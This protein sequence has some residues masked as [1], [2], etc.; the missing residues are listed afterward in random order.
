VEAEPYEVYVNDA[1]IVEIHRGPHMTVAQAFGEDWTA[2][3]AIHMH[4]AAFV[5]APGMPL[6]M[7]EPVVGGGMKFKP[8]KDNKGF[9]FCCLLFAV[10][11]AWVIVSNW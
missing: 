10:V 2:Q 5:A 4:A 9:Y 8:P 3:P 7:S 1:A 6:H 11:A